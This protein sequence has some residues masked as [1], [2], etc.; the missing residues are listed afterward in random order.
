MVNHLYKLPQPTDAAQT[1]VVGATHMFRGKYITT[2]LDWGLS[3]LAW[4]SLSLFFL[5]LSLTCAHNDGAVYYCLPK[6][7]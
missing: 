5:V 1:V 6:T 2:G 7:N 4:L 3:G